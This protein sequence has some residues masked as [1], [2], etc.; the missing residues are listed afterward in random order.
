LS[1][2]RFSCWLRSV[3]CCSALPTVDEPANT[4]RRSP[5]PN[6]PSAGKSHALGHSRSIPWQFQ[7]LVVAI[8]TT[9]RSLDCAPRAVWN[10]LISLLPK[11]KIAN[12]VGYRRGERQQTWATENAGSDEAR[13]AVSSPSSVPRPTFFLNHSDAASLARSPPPVASAALSVGR[14]TSLQAGLALRG[15]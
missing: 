9:M 11:S 12:I 10:F 13:P 3:Y 6:A 2:F 14:L 15:R 7:N 5:H 4:R 8:V 1:S